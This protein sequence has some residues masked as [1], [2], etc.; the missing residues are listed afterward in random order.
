[1]LYAFF[2]VIPRRRQS[3]PKRR[4]MK[5]R[6]RGITQK[7][8]CNIN[9]QIFQNPRSQLQILGFRMVTS[10][11]FRNKDPPV[12]SY[13]RTYFYLGLFARCIRKDARFNAKLQ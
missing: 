4:N 13:L 9:S 12:W 6:R 3:V 5:L 11:V 7:N 8:A 2:W 1:M 10:S